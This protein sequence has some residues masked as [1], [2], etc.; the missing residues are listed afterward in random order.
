M[1]IAPA[2]SVVVPVYNEEE[3]LSEFHR[4]MVAACR[5]VAIDDYELVFV[6]DGSTDRSLDILLEL[7]R[8]D[9]RVKIVD[10]AR[11]YGHQLAL[12]AGLAESAG[13]RVLAIDADLQDPP[14][15]LPI[16]MKQ[17][18][19]GAD[20]V[21][22]Q[23]NRRAGE[24]HL[25]L[26]SASM[27][28]RL[29]ARISDTQIPVDTG[30]FR[31]MSRRVV[32]IIAGLPE[33]HR[34]MRGL[35]A[36]VGLKQVPLRYDRA[37]RFAGKTKYPFFKML[38]FSLDAITAFAAAP[39]RIVFLASIVAMGLAMAAML[40]TLYSFFFLQAVAGWSSLMVVFLFFTSLQLF[41]LAFIGEY[42][43]RTFIESKRRPLYLIKAIHS[44]P[45]PA[46]PSAAREPP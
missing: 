15:L 36:W 40:W 42:V 10:L 38:A 39:L 2:L 18:D 5:D 25:K 6:N 35:V 45:S 7:Q 26:A 19:A 33:A 12:S 34:F 44:A 11:N 22:A 20:V 29:L 14:E 13:D 1:S 31:L 30:D 37:E 16:M 17:M 27:F 9:A 4:R 43:G 23:R 41:A 32:D 8:A 46:A 21:Y 28:Y 24:S 3:C